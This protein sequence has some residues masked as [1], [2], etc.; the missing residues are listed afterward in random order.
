MC[1]NVRSLTNV[2]ALPNKQISPVPNLTE[3]GGQKSLKKQGFTKFDALIKP[4][5]LNYYKSSF[6]LN[7]APGQ[8]FLDYSTDVMAQKGLNYIQ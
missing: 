5:V 4:Y 6:S 2:C 1:A 3:Y 8:I 7:C